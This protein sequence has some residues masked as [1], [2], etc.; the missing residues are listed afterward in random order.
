MSIVEVIKRKRLRNIKE[1]MN[2][3]DPWDENPGL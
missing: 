3:S 1:R 2:I